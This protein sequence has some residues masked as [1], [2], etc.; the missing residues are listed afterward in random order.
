MTVLTFSKTAD[1]SF[2]GGGGSQAKMGSLPFLKMQLL[3]LAHF[4]RIEKAF[5]V[6]V[7]R[8]SQT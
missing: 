8:G 4:Y 6:K 7:E 5:F 2:I 3:L 1:N